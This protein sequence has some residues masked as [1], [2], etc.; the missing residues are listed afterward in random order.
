MTSDDAPSPFEPHDLTTR[1]QDILVVILVVG[2]LVLATLFSV[3]LYQAMAS[4]RHSHLTSTPRDVALI[5][6]WMTI[7]Y[8]ARAY[9]VPEE[10]IWKSLGI[11]SFGNRPK[12]L[13]L[14]DREYAGGKP[15]VIMGKVKAI[16]LTYRREFQSTPPVVTSTP[17]SH[18]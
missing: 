2:G 6:N 18:P 10:V 4:L 15:D 13:F 7:P 12:T 17:G 3:R 1:W 16:I 9:R 5:K 14:L 11:E 8:I